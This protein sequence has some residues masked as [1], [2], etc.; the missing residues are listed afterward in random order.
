MALKI[1]GP[2][3][4]G[5]KRVGAELVLAAIVSGG[6]LAPQTEAKWTRDGQ[7]VDE[8][9]DLPTVANGETTLTLSIAKAQPF[10]AGT[11]VVAVTGDDGTVAQSEPLVVSFD[12]VPPGGTREGADESTAEAGPPLIWDKEFARNAAL[13]LVVLFVLALIPM[14]WA[15]A[16]ILDDGDPTVAQFVAFGLVIAGF[17]A[18]GGAIFVALLELRGRA[19][20]VEELAGRPKE[21][22]R[23]LVTPEQVNELVKTFG[24]LKVPAALMVLSAAFFCG[25]F[26]LAWKEPVPTSPG[27]TPAVTE[28]A[29]TDPAG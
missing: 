18:L 9:P 24:S 10:H 25:A 22:A 13:G 20:T 28:P 27:S 21:G 12:S 15:I 7:L 4:E 23:G 17:M 3:V 1:E 6:E 8:V 16:R 5:A 26:G 19:R 2:H 14:W 11:Y 29:T